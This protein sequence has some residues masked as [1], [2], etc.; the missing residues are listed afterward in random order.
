MANTIYKCLGIIYRIDVKTTQ[1]IMNKS[2]AY[3]CIK[4]RRV[5]DWLGSAVY[6]HMH[7]KAMVQIRDVADYAFTSAF[8]KYSKLYAIKT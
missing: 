7:S 3:K 6:G 5:S 1:A 4:V 8:Q 2:D